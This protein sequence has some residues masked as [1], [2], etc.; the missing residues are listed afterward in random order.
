M[1]QAC[2]NG[3]LPPHKLKMPMETRFVS[4]VVFFQKTLEFANVNNIYYYD[5]NLQLQSKVPCG[6]TW[7][8][9]KAMI[10]TFI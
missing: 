6:K 7:A 5:S 4:K 9:V 3:S 1:G 8:M 2:S 10:K